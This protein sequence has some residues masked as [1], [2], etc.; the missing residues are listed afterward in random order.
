M[1]STVLG[2]ML[3]MAT[4]P[5]GDSHRTIPMYLVDDKGTGKPIGVVQVVEAKEGLTFTPQLTGLPPGSHGFHVHENPSCAPLEKDGKKV[6][7][8][9]AGGHYD[10]AGTKKHEGPAGRGHLGDLPPLV[11]GA[12]GVARQPLAA[13]RLKLADLPG[14]S[15]VIH[16]GGDNYSDSPQALGGGGARIAC[17]LIP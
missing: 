3:S 12:D 15:L 4:T 10:P 9:G 13:P 5:T 14:R 2:V 8:L 16:A 1:L 7:A 11:V 6:A 17:G